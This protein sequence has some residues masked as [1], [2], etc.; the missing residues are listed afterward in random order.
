MLQWPKSSQWMTFKITLE[1]KNE[2]ISPK[3]K[4]FLAHYLGDEITLEG[5]QGQKLFFE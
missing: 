3:I 2:S 4:S 5:H 1:P